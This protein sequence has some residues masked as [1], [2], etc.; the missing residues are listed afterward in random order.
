MEKETSKKKKVGERME[1]DMGHWRET[2]C[3]A[4]D[5]HMALFSPSC[6]CRTRFTLMLD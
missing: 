5:I 2:V 4:F 6:S 1:R 3:T